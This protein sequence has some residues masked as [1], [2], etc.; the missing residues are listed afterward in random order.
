M[1][2][3]DERASIGEAVR[4]AAKKAG[5]QAD[6]PSELWAYFVERVSEVTL[7]KG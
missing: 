6:T 4:A 1:F 2:P 7:W 5:R 3:Y